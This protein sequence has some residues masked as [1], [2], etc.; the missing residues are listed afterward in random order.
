MHMCVASSVIL[1]LQK[2]TAALGGLQRSFIALDELMCPGLLFPPR[3]IF[4]SK[5]SVKW[6]L[7]DVGKENVSLW[8]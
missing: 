8:T 4:A 6:L 7:A 3:F 5:K 1:P 2:R